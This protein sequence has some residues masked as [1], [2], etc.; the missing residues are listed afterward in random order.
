M[1]RMY[2]DD[3]FGIAIGFENPIEPVRRHLFTPTIA[4]TVYGT[5]YPYAIKEILLFLEKS[6]PHIKLPQDD[7]SQLDSLLPFFNWLGI[8]LQ[9]L[10]MINKHPSF[11]LEEEIRL[12]LYDGE[13]AYP[14]THPNDF[15]FPKNMRRRWEKPVSYTSFKM[16]KYHDGSSDI[17]PEQI[18]YCKTMEGVDLTDYVLN[19]IREI[20]VG[21][22]HDETM[23]E[24][25]KFLLANYGFIEKEIIVKK[26]SSP[27]IG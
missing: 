14:T 3:G 20:W 21:P 26:Y 23:I 13:L 19:C 4:N 18:T 5:D 9:I 7:P 10:S 17:T 1:W 27:Y 24:K 2:A 16:N 25:I 6:S 12:L 11:R 15:K 22:R 8:P